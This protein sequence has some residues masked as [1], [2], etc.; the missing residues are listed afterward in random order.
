MTF[1]LSKLVWALLAPGALLTVA[2]A[3][4]LWSFRRHPRLSRGLLSLSIAFCG[5][6]LLTPIGQWTIQPLEAPFP[7]TEPPAQVDGIIVLGGA[8]SFDGASQREAQ[9]NSAADRVT[10]LV[11]LARRYPNAK[12]V[13][14]GGSGLVKDQLHGEAQMIAPLLEAMGIPGER[15]ILES[16]SRNTWEN[17]L[18]SKTLANPQAGETWLLVT[19][20]WHMP[21]AVG[22]FR[23]IGWT[24][25]PYPVDFRGHDPEWAGFDMVKQLETMSMAEKEWIGL[26]SY[27]LLGRSDA[28]FP[29][30]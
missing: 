2:L 4:A 9:L 20:G 26:V 8:S 24:V 25:V 15:L 13:Y 17:A 6:L 23:R 21:R 16:R 7:E 29:A 22:C 10:E 3:L 14:S 19:S 28:L 30:P 18:E 1:L 5:A 11:V 27:R 12:L